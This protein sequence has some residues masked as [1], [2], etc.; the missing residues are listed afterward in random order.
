LGAQTSTGTEYAEFDNIILQQTGRVIVNGAIFDSYT[1]WVNGCGEALAQC[2]EALAQCGEHNGIVKTLHEYPLP[3]NPDYWPLVFF[4]GGAA[5]YLNL[6]KDGDMEVTGTWYWTTFNSVIAKVSGIQHGGVRSLRIGYDGVN[7]TGWAI[8][9]IMQTGVEYRLRGWARGDGTVA[10]KAGTSTVTIWNGTSS[11][12]W[13]EID[14]TFTNTGDARLFLGGADLSL[15]VCYFDDMTLEP[16]TLSHFPTQC[17]EA[18]A[19]C[20]E[21]GAQCGGYNGQILSIAPVDI[22]ADRQN[23]LERIILMVKPM[24]SWCV[25]FVN[26]V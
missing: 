18:L 26:Y 5:T 8:Q 7:P 17:G 6:I 2:G 15:G 24:H 23:D 20:G 25:L 12:S 21:P 16:T 4:I 19:Q 11:V 13:Q 14:V 22:D 3:T 10:P 9:S 1:D